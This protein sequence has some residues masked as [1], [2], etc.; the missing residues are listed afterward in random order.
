MGAKCSSNAASGT[1]S[2]D[3]RR[4]A[5]NPL[6][7]RFEQWKR[8]RGGTASRIWRCDTSSRAVEKV[9]QP[10]SRAND[11]DAAWIGNTAIS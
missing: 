2:P 3:G 7:S 10:A 11:V 6:A 1:Y 4:I 5:Y 8:Y 9:P